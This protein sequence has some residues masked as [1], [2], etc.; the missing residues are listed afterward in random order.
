MTPTRVSNR[1]ALKIETEGVHFLQVE[2]FA[3]SSS[4]FTVG[5]TIKMALLSD[6]DDGQTISVGETAVG[7]LDY[8][9]EWDWFSIQLREGETVSI[10][11]DSVG[12]DTLIY[13]DFPGSASNQVVYDDDSGGGLS[14]TNAQLVYRAPFDSTYYIAVT[15]ALGD[16]VGGYF[17][18]VESAPDGTET[19]SVPAS[20][21]EDTFDAFINS[22]PVLSEYEPSDLTDLGGEVCEAIDSGI[23]FDDLLLSI[24]TESPAD[25][26]LDTA[27]VFLA[28]AVY[29]L[30]P[31]YGDALDQWVEE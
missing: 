8:F 17:L 16:D 28:S 14:G 4:E 23:T 3:N 30:C 21:D 25:W 26:D 18:S 10:Y 13:V 22:D 9:S 12:V 2:M 5:S 15:G 1:G 29:G 27:A 11:A 24:Y 6:P 20:H 31:E 19:V 7:S